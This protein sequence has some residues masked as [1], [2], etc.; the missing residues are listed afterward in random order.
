MV[1]MD[2][3]TEKHGDPGR[4]VSSELKATFWNFALL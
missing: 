4:D 1:M 2:K 3:Q